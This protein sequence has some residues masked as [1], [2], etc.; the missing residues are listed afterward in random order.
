MGPITD[1]T[2]EHLG[3]IDRHVAAVRQFLLKAL[4]DL[5]RGIDPAAL[6]WEASQNHVDDLWFISSKLPAGASR[7]DPDV[8]QRVTTHRRQSIG[9]AETA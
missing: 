7:R 5:E 9:R 6:S 8:V 4:A 2:Q 1:R 3:A